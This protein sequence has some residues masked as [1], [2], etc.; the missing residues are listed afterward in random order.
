VPVILTRHWPLLLSALLSCGD[1]P[2]AP[3]PTALMGEFS[4]DAGQNF[5]I[6][7]LF[8]AVQ[9][10]GDS[11]RGSWSLSFLTT[12]STHDGPFSGTLAGDRLTLHLEPDEAYEASL[13]L[14]LR[15]HPGDSVLTGQ[16]ALV[17]EGTEPLCFSDFTPITLHR[18]EVLGLPRGT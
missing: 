15:V 5:K 9:T 7:N 17:A 18:G 6:Y 12:C 8:L 4:G 14:T 13:D 10:T 16:M 11:I 1:S 2:Y 3:T